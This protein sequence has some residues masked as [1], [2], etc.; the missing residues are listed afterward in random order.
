MRMSRK[1]CATKVVK[2]VYLEI[3]DHEFV[4]LLGPSGCGKTT[5]LRMGC[6][7]KSRQQAAF[8]LTEET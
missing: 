3:R 6:G 7:W 2:G 1:P 4:A 8:S 5:C